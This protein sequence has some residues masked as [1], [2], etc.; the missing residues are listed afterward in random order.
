MNQASLFILWILVVF[1]LIMSSF[2]SLSCNDAYNYKIKDYKRTKMLVANV[3]ITNHNVTVSP[4]IYYTV[5]DG[6]L[7]LLTD[8]NQTCILPIMDSE[9]SSYSYAYNYTI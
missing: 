9:S 1:S 5:Y 2:Y 3:T 8:W 4:T 7:N 6:N